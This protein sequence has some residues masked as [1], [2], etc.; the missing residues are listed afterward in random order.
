LIPL[1]LFLLVFAFVMPFISVPAIVLVIVMAIRYRTRKKVNPF[2][3][4]L[5]KRL[6]LVSDAI[7]AEDEYR[8]QVGSA[9]SM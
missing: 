4:A 9:A 6:P 3:L 7:S 8:I 5:L 1:L 2:L